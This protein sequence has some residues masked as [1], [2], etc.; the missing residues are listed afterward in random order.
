MLVKKKTEIGLQIVVD[1]SNRLIQQVVS[2]QMIRSFK[3]RPYG[4]G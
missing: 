1:D 3:G 2:A 4:W